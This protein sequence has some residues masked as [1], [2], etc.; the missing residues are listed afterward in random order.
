MRR[1]RGRDMGRGRQAGTAAK[2]VVTTDGWGLCR[3][4]DRNGSKQTGARAQGKC[5]AAGTGGGKRQ[6]HS[7]EG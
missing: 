4:I 6:E 5:Y 1:H 3:I 2:A 7:D